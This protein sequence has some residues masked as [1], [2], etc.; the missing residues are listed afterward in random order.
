MVDHECTCLTVCEHCEV[1]SLTA[2]LR[3]QRGSQ[4]PAAA[5]DGRSWK[6]AEGGRG[7]LWKVVE[8]GCG[9]LWKVVE[10]RPGD[11]C[12]AVKGCGRS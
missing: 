11:L 12:T 10:V 7:R 3:M 5:D 8:G 1:T 9:R 2:K 6:V 4:G